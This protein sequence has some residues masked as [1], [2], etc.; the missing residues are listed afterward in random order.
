MTPVSFNELN[1]PAAGVVPP[2]AGGVA[3]FAVANV[4][5][6]I[7]EALGSPVALVNTSADGVPSAGVTKDG[8]VARTALPV[9]VVESP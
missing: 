7:T 4:P 5:R 9:P 6:P 3:A 1:V 8:E 2:I